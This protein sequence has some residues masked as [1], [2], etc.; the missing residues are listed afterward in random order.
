MSRTHL[1]EF[2]LLIPKSLEEAVDY[3]QKHG[4]YLAVMAGGTDLLRQMKEGYRPKY[5]MSIGEIPDLDFVSYDPHEGLRIGATATMATILKNEDV[6][7]NYQALW[8]SAAQN[9]TPQTRNRATVLGNLLRASPAGD[10]CCAILAHG[11]CLVLEGPPGQRTVDIDAF[12]KEYR[13]TARREDELAVEVR[14]P[15]NDGETRSQFSSLKRTSQ[16]LSKV[17][18][19][20]SLKMR[21]HLCLEPRLAMGAVAPIPLRLIRSEKHLKGAKITEDVLR[22]SLES[23]TEEVTPID[24]MRSTAEYRRLVTA[25]LLGRTIEAAIKTLE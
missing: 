25:P 12:W 19:A 20:V 13:L 24:D 5:V 11:G 4:R 2:D 17:N 6:K 14:L 10:C 15:A 9:G 8:Q 1:P 21:R 3:L 23:A 7:E 22:R 16:D 18:A